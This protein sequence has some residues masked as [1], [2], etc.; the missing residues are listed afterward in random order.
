M[1]T[2][3]TLGE[4]LNPERQQK[5]AETNINIKL[6]YVIQIKSVPATLRFVLHC[7]FFVLFRTLAPSIRSC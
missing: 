6:Q 5:Y 2:L 7:I 1:M 3:H 4:A